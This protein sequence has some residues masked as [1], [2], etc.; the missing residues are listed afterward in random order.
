MSVSLVVMRSRIQAQRER[1][2]WGLPKVNPIRKDLP[3]SPHNGGNFSSMSGRWTR[4]TMI[5]TIW[6]DCE[7]VFDR[8]NEWGRVY[9]LGLY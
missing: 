8:R 6:L 1:A 2:V 4:V 5:I 3:E 7:C 9:T